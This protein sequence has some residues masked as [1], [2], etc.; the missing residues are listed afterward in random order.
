[1]LPYLNG[2]SFKALDV[3]LHPLPSAA[4]SNASPRG[5]TALAFVDVGVGFADRATVVD[6]VGFFRIYEFYISRNRKH[7]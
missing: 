4:G 3:R 2:P 7:D 1:V 5:H 6:A